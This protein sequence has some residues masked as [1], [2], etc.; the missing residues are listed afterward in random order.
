MNISEKLCK[1]YWRRRINPDSPLQIPSNVAGYRTQISGGFGSCYRNLTQDDFLNEIS[2]F[3]HK[4][5]SKYMSRR[6]IYKPSATEKD[7]NGNPKWEIAGYDD[8][9]VVCTG[10]QQELAERKSSFFAADGFNIS[11]ESKGKDGAYDMLLSMRD[12]CGLQVA[13]LEVVESCFKTGDGAIYLY[14]TPDGTIDYEVFSFLKGDILYP[15]ID[16]N[17]DEVLYR[18]YSL[19][20]RTAV[21]IF[22]TKSVETWVKVNDDD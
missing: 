18:K 17:G 19:Q 8:V 5:N 11:N 15:G 14:Q 6:A 3:A 20:G 1:N 2:S 12:E 4:I 21:D 22:S 10:I 13:Y 9:E 7:S 16:D